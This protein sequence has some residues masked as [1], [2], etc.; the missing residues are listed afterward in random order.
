[1]NFHNESLTHRLTCR[2]RTQMENPIVVD[3]R[4]V[5]RESSIDVAFDGQ[6]DRAGLLVRVFRRGHEVERF[7]ETGRTGISGDRLTST[8]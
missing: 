6:L 8:R 7:F 5:D 3:L 2:D 1:M 4:A